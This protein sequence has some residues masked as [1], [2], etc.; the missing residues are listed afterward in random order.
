MCQSDQSLLKRRRN[1]FTFLRLQQ[2]LLAGGKEGERRM[3][4]RERDRERYSKKSFDMRRLPVFLFHFQQKKNKKHTH[5]WPKTCS[6]GLRNVNIINLPATTLPIYKDFKRCMCC[7]SFNC[8]SKQ[9]CCLRYVKMPVMLSQ[10]Q[11]EALMVISN[12]RW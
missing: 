12:G 6:A 3:R 1:P 10:R 7:Q 8:L 11:Q 5:V 4:G 2:P 9:P